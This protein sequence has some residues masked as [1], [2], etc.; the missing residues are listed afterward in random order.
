[1][2]WGGGDTVPPP[3]LFILYI[4]DLCSRKFNGRLT[5]FA[6]DTA[7]GYV[8]VETRTLFLIWGVFIH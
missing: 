7:L 5:S 6:D 1:M 3:H 8:K 4:N 2:V